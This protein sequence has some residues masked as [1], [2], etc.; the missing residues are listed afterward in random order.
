MIFL[1]LLRIYGLL[2]LLSVLE[3][4]WLVSMGFRSYLVY[5]EVDHGGC[6]TEL[7][8]SSILERTI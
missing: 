7:T 8:R 3:Y 2:L 1:V 5:M 6:W 4:Y